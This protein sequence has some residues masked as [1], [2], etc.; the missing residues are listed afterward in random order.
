MDTD[1][2][3]EVEQD[4][5]E[6]SR[7]NTARFKTADLSLLLK[8]ESKWDCG[9]FVAAGGKIQKSV[10]VCACHQNIVDDVAYIRNSQSG[11][12]DFQ[13]FLQF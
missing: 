1:C 4:K 3:L 9:V 5:R 2:E 10:Y 12:H 11:I 8:G 7:T 13:Q 6:N